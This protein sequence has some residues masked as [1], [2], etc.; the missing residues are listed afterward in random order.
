MKKYPDFECDVDKDQLKGEDVSM[1]GGDNAP[2]E[3]LPDIE[4][5]GADEPTSQVAEDHAGNRKRKSSDTVDLSPAGT[6]VYGRK[7]PKM[8]RIDGDAHCPGRI[9]VIRGASLVP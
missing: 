3:A 4:D 5:E 2:S 6:L 1:L 7:P 8:R 9:A